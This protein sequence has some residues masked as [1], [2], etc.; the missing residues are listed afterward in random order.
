[1]KISHCLFAGGL[2][3]ASLSASAQLASNH[4][5]L[6][7]RSTSSSTNVVVDLGLIS[8]FTSPSSSTFTISSLASADLVSAYGA[9]WATSGAVSWGII[10]TNGL[11]TPTNY[12][13]ASRSA[14][15]SPTTPYEALSASS[16]ADLKAQI[17][18]VTTAF[19]N[20][21][22]LGGSVSTNSA[23]TVFL[24]GSWSETEDATPSVSFGWLDTT[25]FQNVLSLSGGG[26]AVSDL[27]QMSQNTEGVYIGSFGLNAA[28]EFVFSTSASTFSAVPEPSTYAAIAG[29]LALGFVAFRRRQAKALAA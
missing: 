25:S 13:S 10:G 22:N 9:N 15:D 19:N 8:Q 21:V 14:V 26:W 11:R 28:G 17:G 23:S 5:I 16:L 7:F 4:L 3:L 1:M 6:G 29:V 18:A 27:Y 12:A 24:P 20:A 2:A